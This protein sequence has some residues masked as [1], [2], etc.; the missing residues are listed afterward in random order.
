MKRTLIVCPGRGSYG[1]DTMGTLSGL[2]GRAAQLLN[3]CD[4]HRRNQN[5]PSIS[6]LDS[7]PAF[8]GSLHVAGENASL[9]TFA[10]SFAD[11]IAMRS[12]FDVVGTVG[13]SMGWYTALAL[14]GAFDS[15]EDAIRLVDTMG[16]YQAGNVIGAQL[17]YPL[18]GPDW[19]DSPQRR[20]VIDDAIEQVRAAG[21]QAWWSIDLGSFAIL[22][23]DDAGAKML[24]DVLP[25]DKRGART[26]PA[27]LPMHSAFHTPLLEQ[28][29]ERAFDDLSD[30]RFQPPKVPLV[31]GLGRVHH[32]ITGDPRA[33]RAYT[34]GAQVVDTYDFAFS[35][36][37][38]LAQTAPEVVVLL[39]PG[40]TLGGPLASILISAGWRGMESRADFEALQASD[41]P[42]LLSFGMPEQRALLT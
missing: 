8:K 9:L 23:A 19:A 12:D 25:D 16:S 15:I 34:L 13:N 21:H 17:I 2:T 3:L 40:N 27:K 36:K 32:P 28:T 6:E 29:S 33:L 37:T 26:F 42:V 30:L 20:A 1:R 39:G 4:S 10:C 41:N 11:R 31:D 18:S 7:A 22:A 38:A 35:V 5:R 24:A 14:S